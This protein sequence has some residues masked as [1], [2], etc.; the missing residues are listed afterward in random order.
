ME[1]VESRT[2]LVTETEQEEKALS[3]GALFK[4]RHVQRWILRRHQR[5]QLHTYSVCLHAV[6][7][8]RKTHAVAQHVLFCRMLTLLEASCPKISMATASQFVSR[9]YRVNV[10]CTPLLCDTM[11]GHN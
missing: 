4:N 10:L 11:G 9:R 6:V 7:L 3:Y 8:Y 2:R 1:I 5:L